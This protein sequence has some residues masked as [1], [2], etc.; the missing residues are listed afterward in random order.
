MAGFSFVG[1]MCLWGVIAAGLLLTGTYERAGADER[2]SIA[3]LPLVNLSPNPDDAYFADGVHEEIIS[4]LGKIA[5]LKVIS[6]RSVMEYRERNEN[7]RTIADELGVT[8]VLEGSVRRAGDRVR[9]TTQ[10][11]AAEDDEHLWAENYEREL[12]DIFA[13]QADVARQVAA[14]MRATLTPDEAN[15]IDARP[16]EDLR[17]YEFYLR[18]L[19]YF[20]SLRYTA[21]KARSA[22]RMFTQA[23]DL[24]QDFALA[25]AWLS[26]THSRT[27][28]FR[29]DYS[30]ERLQ[31][32]RDA[33]DR[34]IEL[35]RG[36]PEAHYALAYYY[37]R[38]KH[39]FV[40]ALDEITVAELGR[41]GDADIVALKAYI[42]RR[43]GRWQETVE[44]LER[45]AALDPR[46]AQILANLAHTY[47]DL[48]LYDEA[49]R[50]YRLA[51]TVE[52]GYRGAEFGRA[53]TVLLRDGNLD[54]LRDYASAH[55]SDYYNRW[56]A[57]FLSRDYSAAIAAV[58]EMDDEVRESQTQYAPRS[59]Y[60][61]LALLMADRAAAAH[62][63][64]DSARLVL[65]AAVAERPHDERVRCALGI[66][67]A[68]LGDREAAIREGERATEL[69]PLSKDAWNGEFFVRRLAQIYVLVGDH[70]AAIAKLDHAL[71]IVSEVSV[72]LLRIDPLYDPLRDHP[73]F[74][75]LL[76][77]YE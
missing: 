54:A 7:L 66:V 20:R 55:P 77:K 22:E 4:Q 73:R 47:L 71:S 35:D 2:R 50:Q 41:P 17:A 26:A 21:E 43:M 58:S 49:E 63:S 13:I 30:A 37:Y 5:S 59:L 64:F 48:R 72:P 3:V 23:V 74:Q 18:G 61:G 42:F 62:A 15:R 51:L 69:L 44:L 25:H 11:I 24:D 31:K 9:I 27:Y 39:A 52:P 29:H 10:L 33:A 19:D 38:G 56:W 16:T 45:A 53:K 36:L 28:S 46:N 32:A 60:A 70:D 14:A 76:E 65:E 57:A 67:Y 40:E 68:G 8:H 34:A 1:A 75:A 6:P 12:R